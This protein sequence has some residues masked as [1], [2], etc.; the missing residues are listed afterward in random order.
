MAFDDSTIKQ[1]MNVQQVQTTTSGSVSPGAAAEQNVTVPINIDKELLKILGLTVEQYLNLSD[2]QKLQ[3]NNQINQIKNPADETNFGITGLTVEKTNNTESTLTKALGNIEL[4]QNESLKIQVDADII[5]RDNETEQKITETDWKNM[6]ADE[7]RAYIKI[8]A[9]KLLKDIPEEEREDVIKNAIDRKIKEDKGFTDERWNNMS[10]RRKERLRENLISDFEIAIEKGFLSKDELKTLTYEE[11]LDLEITQKENHIKNMD[12]LKKQLEAAL[13]DKTDEADNIK[14]L[15]DLAKKM[16]AN[17]KDL[18]RK[19]AKKD[20]LSALNNKS[21]MPTTIEAYKAEN[22]NPPDL[23]TEEG[24]NDFLEFRDKRFEKMSP[25]EKAKA[26]FTDFQGIFIY[27]NELAENGDNEKTNRIKRNVLADLERLGIDDDMAE[28]IQNGTVDPAEAQKVIDT[29]AAEIQKI[30]N[31]TAKHQ[32]SVNVLAMN[33]GAIRSRNLPMS[34]AAEALYKDPRFT[35][36]FGDGYRSIKGNTHIAEDMI[37]LAPQVDKQFQISEAQKN[38]DYTYTFENEEDTVLLQKQIADT[39]GE[40]DIDNQ[41]DIYKIVMSSKFDEVQE[42]AANNIYKLDESVRDWASDYT[43]SLGK[44]NLTDA[45]QTEPPVLDTASTSN[46]ESPS[47]NN[48]SEPIINEV[49]NTVLYDNL[50]A[51]TKKVYDTIQTA[52]KIS[53]NDAVKHFKQLT[54]SEQEALLKALPAKLFDKLPIKMCDNFPELI[55]VFVDSGR[56]TE[57]FSKCSSSLVKTSAVKYMNKGDK[58][59]RQLQEYMTAHPE[60]FNKMTQEAVLGKQDAAKN[61]IGFEKIG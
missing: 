11:R 7:R 58:T 21:D 23:S 17:K 16:A 32:N 59:R 35:E 3:V 57:I 14:N 49:T 52:E 22:G 37:R 53:L 55:P 30:K 46:T 60:E 41:D 31:P 51:N 5:R 40:F 13:P 54:R 9:D 45:I 39:M 15:Q 19:K 27:A 48:N 38:M 61:A 1:N 56:G 29:L 10:D 36:S 33:Y 2:E 8:A 25:Q 4:M 44:E 20:L 34:K 24:I 50:T 47:Y 18:Q 43:K 26:I 12:E 42:Y 28:K 6:S